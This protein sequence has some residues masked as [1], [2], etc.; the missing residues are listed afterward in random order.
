[1]RINGVLVERVYRR[2]LGGAAGGNDFLGD[3][4]DGCELAP[5]E[6]ELGPLGRKG[7]RATAPPTAPPA[8]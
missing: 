3:D 4:F 6:K 7:A 1:M 2:R 8:P 5:G